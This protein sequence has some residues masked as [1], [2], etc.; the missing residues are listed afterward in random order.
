MWSALEYTAHTRDVMA[1][2]GYLLHKTLQGEGVSI[3]AI[4]ADDAAAASDYNTLAPADVL[5][6]L[7]ANAGRIA[8]RAERASPA[9]WTQRIRV[10]RDEVLASLVDHGIT[11]ALG[12]LRHAVHEAVHH[13]DDVQRNLAAMT[14]HPEGR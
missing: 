2:N 7:E 3:P 6:D 12:V 1:G 5:D 10:E 4:S 8:G 9:D 14:R 13:L 11:D